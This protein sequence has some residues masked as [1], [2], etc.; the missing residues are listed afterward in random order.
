MVEGIVRGSRLGADRLVHLQG[1]GDFTVEKV[2]S[3]LLPRP[4][5]DLLQAASQRNILM[6]LSIQPDHLGP[7]DTISERRDGK[8][9]IRSIAT[10]S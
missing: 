10:E 1:W 4:F 5:L 9:F 3:C 7:F 6:R 2:S 8:R